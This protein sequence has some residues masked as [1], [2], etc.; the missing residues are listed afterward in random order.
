MVDPV[1]NGVRR[2][3]P[4]ATCS[5]RTLIELASEVCE[6]IVQTKAR[7]SERRQYAQRH[8][9]LARAGPVRRRDG[10]RKAITGVRGQSP[11][12]ASLGAGATIRRAE[13][14]D[15]ERPGSRALTTCH[16]RR[17]RDDRF[18]G[19]N[20]MTESAPNPRNARGEWR[21]RGPIALA[22][23]NAW[24]PRPAATAKWLFGFP[25]YLWPYNAFWL[26]VALFTWTFL[27]PEL[28]AMASFEA[29]WIGLLLARNLAFVVI[30]F[31]GLHLYFH[32]YKG[33]GDVLRFTSE[34]FA[35]GARRFAFSDQVRDNVF[36]A[37]A[38]GVPVFTAYE[39]VTYWAFA[40]GHLGLIGIE[41]GTALFWIW[42][43][44]LIL[45]APVIHAVHFYVGHRLL[46]VRF[47]YRTVHHLHH[48]NVEVG[49]W[50]GLSM[51]PV[52][53]VIYFS[54][55]AVQWLLA[56]HPVN[57]LYQ[58]QLAA[59]YPALGHCGFD[60]LKI[61]ERLGIDGGGYFHYLHH[62]YFECNYGG[63]LAPLD[64]LFGTFHDGTDEAHTA[65]RA[66]ML[67]R[68]QAAA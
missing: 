48:R 49:P 56:L 29:W 25:G 24:P 39:A 42:F 32:V 22:P 19:G 37:L 11:R 14:A 59:F 4:G 55:V 9:M 41:A 45:L 16:R 47:L 52:E 1:S 63:S 5:R 66:R 31:G 23:I 6:R 27:T 38:F 21:P 46:H 8:E 10:V 43:A 7:F 58:I 17:R 35:T 33:Q 50:S 51:H 3:A 13:R 65:M 68:R 57:A 54:T 67:A 20:D 28:G 34:P 2:C 40:N 30:L 53:H 18:T 12:L 62:K 44:A 15:R 61:G 60:T 26:A 36:H 64:K